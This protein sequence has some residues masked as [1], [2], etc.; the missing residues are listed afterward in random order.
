MATF[1]PTTNPM[2]ITTAATVVSSRPFLVRRIEW[3]SPVATTDSCS[4][5]DLNSNTIIEGKCEVPGQ[6]QI[7]WPGPAKLTLPGKAAGLG[8]SG[9]PGGSWQV[10]TITSGTLLI[11]F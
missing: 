10:S 6:S 11:W 2:V 1:T 4:I 7:L 3:F 5:M 9:N 8:T